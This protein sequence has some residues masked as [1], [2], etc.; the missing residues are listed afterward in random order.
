MVGYKEY[1]P[2]NMLKQFEQF[3][4]N[5]KIESLMETNEFSKIMKD[6]QLFIEKEA[7]RLCE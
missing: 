5:Q 2:Q 6:S 3:C 1:E 4:D 7:D